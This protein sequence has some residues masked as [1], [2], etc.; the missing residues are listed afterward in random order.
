MEL[1]ENIFKL[2]GGA[3]LIAIIVKCVYDF[4]NVR[5]L[6]K[7]EAVYQKDIEKLKAVLSTKTTVSNMQYQ[8][9]FDIYLELFAKMSEMIRLT[10]ELVQE[11]K[12]S[13]GNREEDN[14][15]FAQRYEFFAKARNEMIDTKRK[16][17]P[18]YQKNVSIKISEVINLC[19]KRADCFKQ[20]VENNYVFSSGKTYEKLHRLLPKKITIKEQE[21]EKAVR[22]YLDNLRISN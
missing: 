15:G 13:T 4:F 1:T 17:S 10:S 9:E 20:W 6:K 16:Y 18:F 12:E 14:K 22:E 21:I 7:R 8:K 3:N 19:D 5:A 11:G 2:I